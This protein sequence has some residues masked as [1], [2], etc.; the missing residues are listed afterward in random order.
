MTLE[1]DLRMLAQ[2][3][4]AR[5]PALTETIV[6]RLREEVPEFYKLDDPV[7]G[8]AESDAIAASLRDILDG[9]VE[10]RTPPEQAS[11]RILR[12]ARLAAQAD[13]DLHA[14]LR[15]SRVGQAATW[16]CFLEVAD[17]L[18]PDAGQ[19]LPVLRHASQYHFAWND[20]VAASI[21]DAYQKER[22]AFYFHG[23]DRKRRALVRDLLAGI[24]VDEAALG[25]SLRGRHLGIVVWGDAPEAALKQLTNT[26]GW[27]SLTV[28]GTAGTVLGWIGRPAGKASGDDDLSRL[29]LPSGTHLACGEYMNDVEGMRLT[30]R[31][32][33]QA[34]R[35]ARI[36]GQP[37]T[38]YRK[39][40]LEALVLRDLPAVRSFVRQ[41]LGPLYGTAERA[42]VLR[43]TLR[44]YFASGQNAASAA[45]VIGVHERTV[46]YRLRS[47]E[48]WLGTSITSVRD[49]L[50]VALR[51][52]ELFQGATEER[53][54]TLQEEQAFD[55]AP[56]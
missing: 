36:K 30:H 38:W 17:E 40:A 3:V 39:V 23:R 50:S 29:S 53:D 46:A 34:Y 37:I 48:K 7:L 32:A 52:S 24:P 10:G 6:R 35:V 15:T 49:E 45:A 20:R 51:L 56:L 19:R 8:D 25:Y 47:V 33:W 9:L 31:Q 27:Q 13:I 41:E 42:V 12:E 4:E 2:G 5:L 14:L 21:I 22:N 11:D 28:T 43:E 1:D 54:L 18:L 55:G 26:L 44:A 16:D